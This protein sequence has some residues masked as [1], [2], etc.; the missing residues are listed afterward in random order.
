ML[1][2]KRT[3]YQFQ[4]WGGSN[5][6]KLVKMLSMLRHGGWRKCMWNRALTW[7]HLV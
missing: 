6:T 4:N 1:V 3:T 7:M 5:S 2:L